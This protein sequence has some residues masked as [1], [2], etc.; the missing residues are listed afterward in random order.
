MEE[1]RALLAE[2]MKLSRKKFTKLVEISRLTK[3]LG[4]A[5]SKDDR[6]S[7]QL[8]LKMRQ[9]ELEETRSIQRD[10]Q[11]FLDAMDVQ[12][13][14]YVKGLLDG[15]QKPEALEFEEVKISE[16]GRQCR[17]SLEET[18]QLDKRISQK[19]AGENSFYK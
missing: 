7:T 10:I 16:F 8:I 1:R 6:E 15:N 11:A 3:E 5:L 12:E 14:V 9:E 17:S 19:L 13:R 4:D 2:V 18:I